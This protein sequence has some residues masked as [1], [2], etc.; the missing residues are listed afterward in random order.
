MKQQ[1]YIYFLITFFLLPAV[2]ATAEDDPGQGRR[3]GWGR[4][5]ACIAGEPCPPSPPFGAYC[6]SRHADKYG[7]R[8]PVQSAEDARQRL[9][10]FFRIPPEKIL[11]RREL[12]NGYIADIINPDGSISDRVIIDKRHGRIRSIR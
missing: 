11:L 6:P 9:A 5:G 3:R 4:Q 7:A 8:Q 12:R 1:I 10:L 2:S